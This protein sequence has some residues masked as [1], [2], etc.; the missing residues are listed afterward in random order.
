MNLDKLKRLQ[1]TNEKKLAIKNIFL[2]E[3]VKAKEILKKFFFETTKIYFQNNNF[4]IITDGL[5]FTATFEG[6]QIRFIWISEEQMSMNPSETLFFVELNGPVFI[7]YIIRIGSVRKF[8]IPPDKY[9]LMNK[10]DV[11][12]K[13]AEEEIVF[14]QKTIDDFNMLNYRYSYEIVSENDNA[15]KAKSFTNLEELLNHLFKS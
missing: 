1:N 12:I 6:L 3:R 14:Y 5:E 10:E 11:S 4:D 8:P 2:T 9:F 13:L 15:K 7:S